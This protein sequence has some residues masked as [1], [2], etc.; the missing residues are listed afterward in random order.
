MIDIG[1]GDKSVSAEADREGEA[2]GRKIRFAF[3]R[4]GNTPGW[5]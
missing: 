2:A 5:L 1:I 4:I 3:N